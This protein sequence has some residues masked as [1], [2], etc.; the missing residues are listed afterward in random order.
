[1]IATKISGT[2]GRPR[3]FDVDQAVDR[4]M[5]LFHARGYDAVGVA[6][7]VD[8]L[9]IKPPSFYAAFG[10]KLGL[11]ERAL[12]RY[13]KSEANVFATAQEK[14]GSV[15]EVI[16]RTLDNAARIYPENSGVS[17][18]LVLDSTRNSAD[19]EVRALGVAA[20]R[21]AREAIRNFV[22][23]E[24]ADR[25][26]ELA[27]LVMI[28]LAGMSSAARDGAD[29]ATLSRFAEKTARVFRREVGL[30]D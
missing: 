13:G 16:G 17:G 3:S 12:E 6:E 20:R 28:A 23:T 9:G 7:L 30:D 21:I 25:A 4:A 11:L 24:Y 15:V 19:A 22:A 18:C 8:D 29:E 2:R 1:M 5:K 14:G 27:D 10:S 26:G